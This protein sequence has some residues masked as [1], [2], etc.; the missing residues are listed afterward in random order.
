MFPAIC[1]LESSLPGMC[2]ALGT[3]FSYIASSNE[4]VIFNYGGCGGNENR[5]ISKAVCEA[6]C[7]E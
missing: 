4:C 6:K 7:K 3:R 1:G 2:K 5:F